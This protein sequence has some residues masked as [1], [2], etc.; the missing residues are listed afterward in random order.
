MKKARVYILALACV[1]AVGLSVTPLISSA[2]SAEELQQQ[3]DQNSTQIQQLNA[4]IAQYQT[5]LDSTTKQKNTLQNTI[6]QLTL[7]S[8]QL[9]AKITVTQSQIKTTQL[10]I[11]QLS[12]NITTTQS[13]INT[14]Q[15]GLAESL[16]RTAELDARPLVL[17]I[18]TAEGIT[19]AWDDVNALSN[20]SE[21]VH[22]HIGILSSKK[23]TLTDTKTAAEQKNAQLLKQK[24]TLASQQGSLTAT[25]KAQSDLLAQT[26]NQESSY[27]AIISQKKSQEA[28]LE[29][30][31]SDLKSKY[32]VAVNPDQVTPA[33]KGVLKWPLDNVRITQYFGNTPFAATGA[34][35]GK[36]HNGI[37]LA[38][39][40]GTPVHAALSGTVIGTGNTD[41]IKG[42]YS[43]GKWVMVKHSNGL[44]T[45]YA[46][47]SQIS[48]SQGQSV[49]TGQLLGYSGE[50]GYA[51][52]P[53]LHF[54]VYVTAV[55][56]ILK[57]GQA[58]NAATPC[59]NAVMPVPPLA[60]YLNPLNYL[61][62][63]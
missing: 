1:F 3:I 43:F 21:A 9:T 46:H 7:Q 11:Q 33:G 48:V 16:R 58:T 35:N 4:E 60:G 23:Q 31:L 54:G 26:K 59:A 20:L 17:L 42:C 44:S 27:Q 22:A 47:F 57:L 32:N 18:L 62:N 41:L 50:T 40:I 61:P 36:G 24:Q 10:Q 8:K 49:A 45:M 12:G 6:N 37:D 2:Q 38:A 51:T 53:H 39:P 55:T 63:I 19:T 56:Q 34:Y 5:Q 25:K 13:S 52:G 29:S 14:E 15:A 28:T 30:A